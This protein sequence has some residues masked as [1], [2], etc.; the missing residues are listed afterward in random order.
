MQL[1]QAKQHEAALA[2]QTMQQENDA[3]RTRNKELEYANDTLQRDMVRTL[4]ALFTL[5]VVVL[6]G[7]GICDIPLLHAYMCLCVMI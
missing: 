4:P 7:C 5:S 6:C 3:L 1:L 2:A